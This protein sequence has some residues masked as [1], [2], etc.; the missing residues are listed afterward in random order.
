MRFDMNFIE[1]CLNGD[2]LLDE[3]DDAVEKWHEGIEGADQELSEYL[4]MK[5]E[6][7]NVWITSPSVLPY[8]FAARRNNRSLTQE[9]EKDRLQMA[10]RAGNA[11]DAEKME[12]WLKQIGKI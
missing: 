11:D 12:R 10:A 6:E 3:V 8:I 2:A 5:D 4:G 7:Y 1:K 9:L